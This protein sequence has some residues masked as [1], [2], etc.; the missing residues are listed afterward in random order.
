MKKNQTIYDESRSVLLKAFCYCFFRVWWGRIWHIF[1]CCWKSEMNPHSIV[2]EQPP[3]LYQPKEP[4]GI[5]SHVKEA[6]TKASRRI[7]E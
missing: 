6:T 7:H 5:V 3:A 1:G 2:N 4:N